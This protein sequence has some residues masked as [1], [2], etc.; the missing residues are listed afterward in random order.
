MMDKFYIYWGRNRGK[1][2]VVPEKRYPLGRRARLGEGFSFL[3]ILFL[4]A[5]SVVRSQEDLA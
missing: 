3:I 1:W 2:G 5:P 4:I